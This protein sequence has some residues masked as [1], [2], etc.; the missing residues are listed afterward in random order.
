MYWPL[1]VVVLVSVLP[2]TITMLRF[3]RTFTRLSRQAQDQA[4]HVATVVEESALGLRAV[5]SFGRED[6]V[7]D[8]F[9]E[10]AVMLHDTQVRK[11]SVSARFWTLL[12]VIPNIT[13]IIVLG[14]GAWPPARGW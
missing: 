12:E 8:R 2:V 14:F 7:Y 4:G 5:K 9:D 11:V 6:Y 10:Q 3:E 13:L 1:G